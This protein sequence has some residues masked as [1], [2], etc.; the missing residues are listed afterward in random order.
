MVGSGLRYWGDVVRFDLR[1][2]DQ[3]VHDKSVHRFRDYFGDIYF[4][5]SGSDVRSLDSDWTGFTKITTALSNNY[6]YHFGVNEPTRQSTIAPYWTS[7]KYVTITNGVDASI[8]C[9]TGQKIPC[10][11]DQIPTNDWS[12]GGNSSYPNW[13]YRTVNANNSIGTMQQGQNLL[14]ARDFEDDS[15][16]PRV[17]LTEGPRIEENKHYS[18][19]IE[20]WFEKHPFDEI[21]GLSNLTVCSFSAMLVAAVSTSY[22][23]K[24]MDQ[25]FEFLDYVLSA[26][27]SPPPPRKFLFHENWLNRAYSYDPELLLLS[28]VIT[29]GIRNSTMYTDVTPY[30]W[31]NWTYS[32]GS[33]VTP[34]NFTYTKRPGLVPQNNSFGQLGTSMV[35]SIY[36]PRVNDSPFTAFPLEVAVGG[37]L[38][39]LLSWVLPSYSQYTM[40]FDQIPE[41]FRLGPPVGYGH[42]YK[43]EVYVQG[44][45]FRLSSRTAYLGVAVLLLHAVLAVTSSLWQ[46]WRRKGIVRAWSTV[47]DYVCLRSGSPSL[48]VTHPN[49]C[50]GIAGEMALTSLV[51]VVDTGNVGSIPH[52]EIVAVND[53]SMAENTAVDLVN[54]ELRYGFVA[55]KLKIKRE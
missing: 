12:L 5:T 9:R 48:A 8:T 43:Y 34:D 15:D 41:K 42:T 52:L 24:T 27:G 2:S 3:D 25:G 10:M 30:A 49:T 40:P 4:N 19:S 45:G 51:R 11:A 1:S 6:K 26:D 39:Y 18:D 20:V 35:S 37:P 55:P 14:M 44:Y 50:A 23:T 21:S 47:P 22:G 36:P 28:S 53:M 7:V 16:A 29:T 31:S 32:S 17:W 46:L 13:C 54:T 38:T 33:M